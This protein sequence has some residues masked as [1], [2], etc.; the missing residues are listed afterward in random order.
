VQQTVI[1][2]QDPL[3]LLKF[4]LVAMFLSLPLTLSAHFIKARR[5]N[6]FLTFSIALSALLTGH[7]S[8]AAIQ[9]H[10]DLAVAFA[11]EVATFC[12]GIRYLLVASGPM[13][14]AIAMVA[15]AA[16]VAMFWAL[17]FIPG[18]A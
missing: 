15:A 12:L 10:W 16:S 11:S 14:F 17:Q 18:I 1:L 7:F 3:W 13:S 5:N 2:V 4:M 6:V 9:G 8:A